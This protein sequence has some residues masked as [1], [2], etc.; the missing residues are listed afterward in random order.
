MRAWPI[1]C[2]LASTQ[3]EWDAEFE[4]EAAA[5]A[6]AKEAVLI[7]A[8]EIPFSPMSYISFKFQIPCM[9]RAYLSY[10]ICQEKTPEETAEEKAKETAWAA[11]RAQEEAKR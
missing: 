4:A 6:A 10:A 1:I 11:R 2:F 5:A 7:K 3:A 8:S 9:L